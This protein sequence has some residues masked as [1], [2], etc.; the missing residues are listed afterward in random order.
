[1]ARAEIKVSIGRTVRR[2]RFF[3]ITGVDG[4]GERGAL[5][6]AMHPAYPTKPYVYAYVTRTD[7][8]VLVNELLR[9]RAEHGVGVGFRV[10]FKWA[11]TSATN[12]NG[13][14]ILFGPDGLLYIVTGE[15]ADPANSQKLGNLRGKVLRIEAG[16]HDPGLEPVRH[17]DLRLR[18]PQLVRDDV[19][20]GDRRPV[21]DRER[22][23]V[24]R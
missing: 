20:P 8:G 18:H 5:G 22:S 3:D 7:H 19:R 6:L 12:H 10:L 17:P 14:H 13:G 1:M 16:R 4:T 2:G 21:G 9:I 11:V 24:Q 23:G 15:N